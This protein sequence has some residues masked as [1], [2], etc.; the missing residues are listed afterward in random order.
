MK[1]INWDSVTDWSA[2]C[3]AIAREVGCYARDVAKE[4]RKR[5]LDVRRRGYPEGLLS[6]RWESVNWGESNQIL[7]KRFGISNQAV[8]Q[9][10]KRLTNTKSL[11][12]RVYF[13]D[14]TLWE[15]LPV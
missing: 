13:D 11:Y 2:S 4:K 15:E 8:G 12:G 6:A 3:R 14:G 10:R 5:G 7:S 9:A 1:N